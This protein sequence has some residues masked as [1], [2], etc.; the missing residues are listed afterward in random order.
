MQTIDLLTVTKE[1]LAFVAPF[2]LKS[3]RKDCKSCLH[4]AILYSAK[5][6]DADRIGLYFLDVHAILGWFDCAFRASHKPLTFSTGPHAKYT[7]KLLFLCFMILP[8][9][10][11]DLFVLGYRLE[12]NRLL[13]W[14]CH[15]R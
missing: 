6:R 5:E 14:R 8:S 7:R 11:T 15:R 9:L 10:L 12:A 4:W 2:T 1:E 3:T 13:P